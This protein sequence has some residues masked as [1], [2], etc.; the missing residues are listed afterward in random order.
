MAVLDIWNEIE[1]KLYWEQAK[2]ARLMDVDEYWSSASV[3]EQNFNR[4]TGHLVICEEP[5]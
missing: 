4:R 1:A 5:E 3:E 2:G